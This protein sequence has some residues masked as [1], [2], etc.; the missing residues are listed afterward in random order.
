MTDPSASADQDS[1]VCDFLG[2]AVGH[3]FRTEGGRGNALA[4]AC[5]FSKGMIPSVI[6]ATA[7]LGRDAFLLAGLGAQV[8]LIERSPVVHAALAAGI[9]AA[10]ADVSAAGVAGRMTLLLGDS[11]RLLAQLSADVVLVD[12]M[13]PPRGNTALVKQ[14]MRTLRSIVGSDPDAL[15]LMEAALVCARR[16]VVLKWPLRAPPMS[17]LRKPSHQIAGKTT[18]YDV[19]V[20]GG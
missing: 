12:P 18:R 3:R 5:G 7:G 14:E 9:A 2:G 17:G 16:R 20:L 10:R 8:T 19:F 11:R 15:E 4:R 6:D 1:L 13:H